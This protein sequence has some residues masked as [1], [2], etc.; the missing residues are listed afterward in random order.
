MPL[1][2]LWVK[3]PVACYIFLAAALPAL[4]LGLGVLRVLVAVAQ[5]LP[6]QPTLVEAAL[7]VTLVVPVL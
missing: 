6:V 5:T 7:A 1:V 3:F 2:R 4:I